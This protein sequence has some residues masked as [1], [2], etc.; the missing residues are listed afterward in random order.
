MSKLYLTVFIIIKWAIN[1]N[2]KIKILTKLINLIT[3]L[4]VSYQINNK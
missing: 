1:N 4:K 2:M 3:L